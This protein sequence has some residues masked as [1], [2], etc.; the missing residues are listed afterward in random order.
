MRDRLATSLVA[1]G[2][3]VAQAHQLAGQLSQS[4]RSGGSGSTEAI[5]LFVRQDFAHAT[6]AVLYVMAG[7]MAVTCLLA[8]VALPRASSVRAAEPPVEGDVVGA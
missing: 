8:A 5:P 3:P 1:Q 6:Q 7:V 2:A 4:N